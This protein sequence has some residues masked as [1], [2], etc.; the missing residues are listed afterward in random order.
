MGFLKAVLVYL[1]TRR[2]QVWATYGFKTSEINIYIMHAD[3][4]FVKME[5]E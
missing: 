1:K 5:S 3:N 2:V 4:Y